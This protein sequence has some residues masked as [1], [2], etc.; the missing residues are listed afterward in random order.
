MAINTNSDTG[1]ET[2][3]CVHKKVNRECTMGMNQSISAD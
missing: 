1:N 3:A 2:S